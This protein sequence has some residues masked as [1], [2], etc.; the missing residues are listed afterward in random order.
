MMRRRRRKCRHCGQLFRPDPRNLR[1]QRYCSARACRRASKAASQRRWLAKAARRAG[2]AWRGEDDRIAIVG[3]ALRR[4]GASDLAAFRHLLESGRNAV[5][6]GRQDPG[7]WDGVSGDPAGRQDAGCYGG[8]IEGIDRFDARFF[9]IRPIEART[10]DPRQRLLL[11]TSWVDYGSPLIF[12]RIV[13]R[14]LAN[15]SPMPPRGLPR[16]LRSLGD[17]RIPVVAERDDQRL[18]Q[19]D[20]RGQGPEAVHLGIAHHEVEA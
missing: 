17:A 8:F 2:P 18:R 20:R 10:M 14:E 12:R 13:P 7:D 5:T 11:E 4:P 15:Q 19:H 9:G 1:H 16:S 6:D 3:M